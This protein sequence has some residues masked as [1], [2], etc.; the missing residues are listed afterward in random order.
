MSG[1]PQH[2]ATQGDLPCVWCW[3]DGPFLQHL[4]EPERPTC[5]AGPGASAT[6]LDSM[7]VR[8]E[9]LRLERWR[10]RVG[11]S[12]GLEEREYRYWVPA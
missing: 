12:L 10:F 4:I 7:E 6:M 5:Y 1:C 2:G 3:R 9:V 11:P 8:S